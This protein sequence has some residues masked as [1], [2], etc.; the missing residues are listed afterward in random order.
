MKV[1]FHRRDTTLSTLVLLHMLLFT[2]IIMDSVFYW[3]DYNTILVFILLPK[4]HQLY[5]LEALLAWPLCS[6][7]KT[8]LHL[9]V[10]VFCFKQLSNFLAFT[11]V[12]GSYNFLVPILEK[13]FTYPEVVVS[14]SGTWL[15]NMPECLVH[16]LKR[17][18]PLLPCLGEQSLQI[19]VHL[20]IHAYTH[21]F[22]CVHTWLC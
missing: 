2:V 19:H 14:F 20:L 6:F 5:S 15:A 3:L 21:T 17:S 4:V 18:I 1:V 11:D 8:S 22:F 9:F 13:L 12:R 16:S 7:I 10:F